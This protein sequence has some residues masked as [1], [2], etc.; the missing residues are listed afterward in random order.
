MGVE[1]ISRRSDSRLSVYSDGMKEVCLSEADSLVG[2]YC[3]VDGKNKGW[4]GGLGSGT[5]R[6]IP[7][8]YKKNSH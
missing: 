7:N 4:G 3:R 8:D 1:K 5:Q 6:K 2:T